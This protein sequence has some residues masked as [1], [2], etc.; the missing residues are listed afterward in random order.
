MNRGTLGRRSQYRDI[1]VPLSL[2]PQLRR[3]QE[4][5]ELGRFWWLGFPEEVLVQ[6][7]QRERFLSYDAAIIFDHEAG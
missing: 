7:L 3:P 5:M 4:G 2:T 1:L 6:L